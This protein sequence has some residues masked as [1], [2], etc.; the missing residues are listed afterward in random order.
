[1]LQ[2]VQFDYLTTRNCHLEHCFNAMDH[3]R[4]VGA[5]RQ[6]LNFEGGVPLV[7]GKREKCGGEKGRLAPHALKTVHFDCVLPIE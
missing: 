6:S 1:M 3:L 7:G 2:E 4:L 5:G